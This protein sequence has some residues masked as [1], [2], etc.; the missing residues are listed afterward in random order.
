MHLDIL[1][2]GA[3]QDYLRRRGWL[4]T[5]EVVASVEIPGEGNM[6][7]ILRVTTSIRSLIV[8]QSRAYVEKNPTLPAPA[9]RAVIEGSFY[10]EIQSIPML[11]SAMP[12]LMGIDRENNILVLEDVGDA[13]AYTFLYHSGQLLSEADTLTLTDYLSELHYHFA[14]E[15]PGPI[16]TNQAMRLLNHESIFIAPFREDNGV[17]LDTVQPGLAELTM[18]CK[19]DVSLKK[20]VRQLGELYLSDNNQ[21]QTGASKTLLHGDYY[22]GSWLQTTHNHLKVIDP[23]FCFYG[24]AEF[25]LGILIAHLMLAQQPSAT[26]NRVLTNYVKPTGFNEQLRQQFTS[27]ELLRRLVEYPQ[28]PLSLSIEEKRSLLDESR[29]ILQ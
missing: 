6:N 4:D 2:T 23:E 14:T 15:K 7:Y 26:I 29:Q 1:Q 16:F 28:L 24:P 20:I 25:D 27:V 22:P 18:S 19:Q 21:P 8:K 10:Q 13:P 11:A 17:N 3:L 9:N 5:E 12:L